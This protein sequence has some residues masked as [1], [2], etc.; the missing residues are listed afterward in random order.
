MP[1]SLVMCSPQGKKSTLLEQNNLSIYYFAWG[2][3]GCQH[4]FFSIETYSSGALVRC[5]FY[6][7][8]TL[9]SCY[10][11]IS[12]LSQAECLMLSI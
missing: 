7:D 6:I 1:D 5:D 3:S 10:L 11:E 9:I 4:L 12:A 2:N 8:M